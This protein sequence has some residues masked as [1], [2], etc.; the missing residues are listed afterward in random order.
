MSD[1]R[2]FRSGDPIYYRDERGQL[3]QATIIRPLAGYVIVS[4]T[5]PDGHAEEVTA[6]PRQLENAR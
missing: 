2:K 5:F 1:A 6:L 4:V 3:H